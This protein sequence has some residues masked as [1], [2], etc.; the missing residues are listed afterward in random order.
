MDTNSFIIHVQTEDVFWNHY[1]R[2]WKKVWYLKHELERLLQKR[3]NKKVIG[4]MK[5]KLGGNIVK[6]FVGLKVNT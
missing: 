6:K 2:C 1:K 4:L 3:K 5:D